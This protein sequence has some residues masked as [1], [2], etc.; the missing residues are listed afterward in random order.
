MQD[1]SEAEDY[2]QPCGCPEEYHLADCPHLTGS[3]GPSTKEEWLELMSNEG[4]NDDQ[5]DY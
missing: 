3:Y 2:R 5:G 4:W 1:P